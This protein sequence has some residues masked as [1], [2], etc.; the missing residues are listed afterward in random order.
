LV[1]GQMVDGDAISVGIPPQGGAPYAPFQVRTQMWLSDPSARVPATATATEIS[2]GEVIGSVEQTQA[3]FCSN[4]GVHDGWLY[5]GEIHVRFW[6][7]TL[8]NLEGR[9]VEVVIEITPEGEDP[10]T[11]QASGTLTVA[12]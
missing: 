1:D 3:F 6:G 5:G 4:T 10:I 11:A 2:T 9:E 8:D 7:I 12:L